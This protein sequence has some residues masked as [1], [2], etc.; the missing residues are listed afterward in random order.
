MLLLNLKA[1]VTAYFNYGVFNVPSST[2]FLET[3]LTI[4]GKSIKHV[5]V[6]NGYQASVNIKVNIYSGEKLVKS[7]NYNLLSPIDKDTLSYTS[8]IDNQRYSL[9]N[10]SYRVELTLTDNNDG[11]KKG[12][13]HKENIVIS[14]L[15]AQLSSSSIQPLESFVKS[16]SSSVITKSG[17]DL[18]PYNVNFYAGS[19]NLLKFYFEAY[20]TDTVLGRDKGFV[21]SYYIER[22]E[23]MFK[24]EGMSGFKKQ[25]TAKVNPLLAQLDISKLESGNYYL[26]VE[27]RDAASKLQLE[28]KWFFQR[29]SSYKNPLSNS[30]SRSVYEFFGNYSNTDT[31]KMFVECLWPISTTVE[32]EWQI[33]VS[34]QKNPELM[35]K[36][37]VDYWQKKAGDS[38]DPLQLWLSYYTKVLEVNKM[39]KCGKQ[40]GYYTDR[41][42][43]YL[44]YGKPDQRAQRPSEPDAYPYE[45]WQYYRIEDKSNGQFYS[46]KKF[47]FANKMI[48]DDCFQLIHSDVRGELNNPKWQYE[49]QKSDNR[50]RNNFDKTKPN[51]SYGNN[52]DDLFS[53]P[54]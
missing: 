12:F 35:K 49:I 19:Q 53:N 25:I 20:G 24:P 34:V 36:Y 4:I 46:N 41:G 37:I 30:T 13:T 26:V 47:V 38:L 29:E 39:F 8:F 50:D 54:R 17:Y 44:Q 7:D 33:N 23:D 27:L 14:F 22:K 31:L 6:E 3:Y 52:A 42:R 16:A 9:S 5:K 45:I 40:K 21:Y 10:G 32:R 2:P 43:V 18:I 15:P 48:A 1:S 51:S 11:Q 28:R